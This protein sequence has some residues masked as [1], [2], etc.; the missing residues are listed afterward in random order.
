MNDTKINRTKIINFIK[1]KKEG[2]YIHKYLTKF[3]NIK[4][5]SSLKK[6]INI[7]SKKTFALKLIK[8]K[9]FE[10]LKNKTDKTILNLFSQLDKLK[11]N[12]KIKQ[13]EEKE[14]YFN[15]NFDPYFCADNSIEMNIDNVKELYKKYCNFLNKNSKENKQEIID[16]INNL[17]HL[18]S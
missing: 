10:F 6:Y 18:Q 16:F 4:N 14:D 15:E 8:F 2:I 11:E 17:R 12:I 9:Y 7:E 3:L 1:N 5:D 13:N